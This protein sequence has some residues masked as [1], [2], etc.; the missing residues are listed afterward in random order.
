MMTKRVLG[1]LVM[2]VALAAMTE[3]VMP[4]SS[5]SNCRRHNASNVYGEQSSIG[6]PF[7]LVWVLLESFTPPIL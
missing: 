7:E 2:V 6:N 5:C 4:A 1:R 3:G